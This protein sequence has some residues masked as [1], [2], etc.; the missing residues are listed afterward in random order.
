MRFNTKV[1]AV[2]VGVITCAAAQAGDVYKYTDSAGKTMY[3][4]KPIPGAILVSSTQRPV[5]AARRSYAEQQSNQN[6]SLNASNQRIAEG[7]DNTRVAA[8]VAQDL[9]ASRAERCKQARD[10]YN[11]SI[12][13]MRM[14]REVNG[15]RQYLSE[16]ELTKARV[17]A[18]RAVD[19][20][21]GPQG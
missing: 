9:A 14:Y 18:R 13:S 12:Q 19:T 17:D 15:Q 3:T 21:C 2:I 16:A 6:A 4:D 1:L 5:E 7:Q 20:V 10:D 11:K 8:A